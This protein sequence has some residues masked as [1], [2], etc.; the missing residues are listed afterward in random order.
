M[1]KYYFLTHEK[2][3]PYFNLASEEYLL[4]KKDEYFIYIW[5]ND[6]SV[7]LGVNQDAVKEVNLEYTEKNGVKVARR[8]TGGGAVY[9]DLNNVCYT[10]IAP[11]NEEENNYV[12]F[13]K[14]VI[15]YLKE[16][17]VNAEFSGRN[18][19][20]IDGKK[21]SGNAQKIYKDRILHHGTLLFDSNMNALTKALKENKLKIESKGIK[22]I[23]ARVTNIKEHLKEPITIGEFI[24]GL[25][26]YLK[27]D[28]EEYKFTEIDLREINKL[29]EQKYSTFEWNVGSSPKGKITFIEK[30]DFG[31]LSLNFDLTKGRIE[32]AKINGDFFT[33]KDIE[34]F[35]KSLNGVEL[36]RENLLEAFSQIVEYIPNANP[37][38]IV[39]KLLK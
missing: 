39:E 20:T 17:G 28:L 9:H 32:N 31:I 12:K 2:T 19:I 13:T 25:K 15:E 14:P 22:S 8:L 3:D 21:I 27:K 10:I 34:E 26:D 4:T 23:R 30:F 7:I 24:S 5:Q 33:V 11:F 38:E 18:D 16:L 35:E 6:N 37:I 36:K 29:K 1:E